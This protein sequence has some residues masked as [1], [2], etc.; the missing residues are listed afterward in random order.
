MT[1]N[2][3][4]LQRCVMDLFLDEKGAAAFAAD[5]CAF[6]AERG[7]DEPDQAALNR[8][9]PRLLTYRNLIRFALED[10]LP[11]CFPILQTLLEKADLWDACVD[12]FLA[13]R[14]IQSS[15]YRD[16]HPAF[17]AWLASSGWGQDTWP[18]LLQLAHFEYIE[19]E[20]L[21]WPDEP[22]LEG[23]ASV[24][25]AD[26][27]VVFDG[28]ARN[29]AYAFAVHQATKENPE[30]DAGET[31]LLGY[32]DADGDFMVSELSAHA[33]A[34]LARCLEGDRIGKAASALD[35]DHIEALELLGDLRDK[36]AILGFR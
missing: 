32:R 28:T 15:Y 18:F 16:I 20:I 2:T 9:K 4:A 3:L 22:P 12:A 7:L 21:R 33:S 8:F 34:F 36:G 23:L 27:Q 10:P 29:L 26:L 19:V 24:P 14:F 30:P 1:D 13:S 35:L 25:A 11:D 5:A 31:F 17:V 6:G